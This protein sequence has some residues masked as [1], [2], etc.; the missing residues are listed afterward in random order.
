MYWSGALVNM[1][2]ILALAARG[3]LQVRRG[4]I[5]AH[6]RSMGLAALLVVAFLLSFLVKSAFLGFEDFSTWTRFH[7]NN[8]R[9]HETFVATMLVA[10]GVAFIRGRR[11]QTTRLVTKQPTDPVPE[12]RIVARHRRAGWVAIACAGFG[13]ATACIVLYGMVERAG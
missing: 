13:F 2:V 4:A 11:L 5:D 10:A 8:L 1:G 3:V 7:V 12:P 9:V 6:K